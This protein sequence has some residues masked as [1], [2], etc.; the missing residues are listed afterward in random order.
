MQEPI[1]D[2]E[3]VKMDEAYRYAIIDELTAY[4]ASIEPYSRRV[5]YFMNTTLA[6]GLPLPLLN[7]G[8]HSFTYIDSENKPAPVKRWGLPDP[9][10]DTDEALSR[11]LWFEKVRHS[12]YPAF[13]QWINEPLEQRK[14]RYFANCEDWNLADYARLQLTAIDRAFL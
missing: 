10:S 6:L 13:E 14:A 3:R 1:H 7:I 8:W 5:D 4:M 9:D 2:P 11:K 12:K